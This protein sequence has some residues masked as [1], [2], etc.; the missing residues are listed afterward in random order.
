TVAAGW[1]AA[2]RKAKTDKPGRAGSVGHSFDCVRVTTREIVVG[3][4]DGK[5]ELRVRC[6]TQRRERRGQDGIGRIQVGIGEK[7]WASHRV[8]LKVEYADD[9]LAAGRKRSRLAVKHGKVELAVAVVVDQDIELRRIVRMRPFPIGV[10]RELNS[11][12]TAAD[13]DET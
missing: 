10:D 7:E 11:E 2:R 3:R 1:N 12:S 4:D 8:G 9:V 5:V 6:E 13:A